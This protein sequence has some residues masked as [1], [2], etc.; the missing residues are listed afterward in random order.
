VNPPPVIPTPRPAYLDVLQRVGYP[1]DVVVTDFETYFDKTYK[2]GKGGLSTIGYIMDSRYEEIGVATLM[3][4]ADLPFAPKQATFWPNVEE[5][6]QWMQRKY[7]PNLE[8]CT[9]VIQNAR[10]D[11]L[12]LGRKHDIAPPYV[13]DTIALS[14]HQDARN[15]HNLADICDRLGLPPKGDTMQF[16]GKHWATMTPDEQL[17]MHQYSCN[18]AER[19]WDVF[20]RLLPRLTRPEVEIPLQRHTL[21][22]FLEPE[23]AFDFTEADR[24]SGLMS[25]QVSK[26]M[27]EG[28]VPKDISGNLSFVKLLGEALAET[29]ER[30]PMK[31]GKKGMIA[32]LAK[33]D[34]AVAELKRHRNPRV[35]SLIKAR[36]AVKSWPLH[37]RRLQA[38]TAQAR[39]AGGRLPN[40]LSYYGAHTGRWSGGE[41]INTCNLPTRG[42]GLA[43]EMKHCLVAPEGHVLLLADLAAIEARGNAWISGQGDLRLAFE[44]NRDVYSEFAS[45]ALASPCRKAMGSDPAPVKS[46]L[47]LRRAFGK[48]CIL[49]LGY[50]MGA[51]TFL[52]RLEKDPELR[53]KVESGEF[54]LLFCKRHV[55]GYR[56]KYSKICTFWRSIEDAFKFTTKY[57]QPRTLH[58]LSFSRDG[59]TTRMQL[60]SGRCMFYPH[61]ACG[62]D[63]RLRWHWGDLWGGTLTE[64]VV[65]A[66]SRDLLAE[67]MLRM[68]ARG[69]R[70]GHHVYDSVVAVVPENQAD[71]AA[72]IVSDELIRVPEWA[73]GWPLGVELS[74]SK[75][76]E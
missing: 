67:A 38:M 10:F 15:T 33:D 3:V 69:V 62:A 42:E 31:E 27:P 35:R 60:P 40:P 57:G 21:R 39:A 13:V 29:G 52:D 51:V 22:L 12:I 63:G 72:T 53:A 74:I 73:K 58:G 46:L 71:A 32:A 47:T 76:Y 43:K 18:D 2:M 5:Q 75:R 65:Q 25:A 70:I 50:G 66:M 45:E 36:A 6:L 17:A 37:I 28:L 48:M 26:D 59:T 19:E 11:G 23:L 8:R 68:E 44:Q 24:L 1:Q 55:D 20:T 7:G 4:D 61:A 54:D 9:V 56:N 64:N 34:S 41:G 14:R 16:S 49:A 30:V